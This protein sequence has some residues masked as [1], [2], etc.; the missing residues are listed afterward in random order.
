MH[1]SKPRGWHTVEGADASPI[2]Q[3]D[4]L[5]VLARPRTQS[6]TR[7]RDIVATVAQLA[8]IY[9]IIHNSNTSAPTN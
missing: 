9:L 7:I 6:W 8:T 4:V 1:V 2:E 3:G 5:W